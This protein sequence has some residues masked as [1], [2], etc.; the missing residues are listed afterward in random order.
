MAEENHHSG[1]FKEFMQRVINQYNLA[2]W[3][4]AVVVNAMFMRLFGT[5]FAPKLTFDGN[6]TMEKW[7]LKLVAYK[8][9]IRLLAIIGDVGDKGGPIEAVRKADRA[10]AA[11]TS[12]GKSVLR[13]AYELTIPKY[14]TEKEVAVRN[15]IGEFLV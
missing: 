8:D 13:F 3:Q 5:A 7:E 11:L 10:L 15:A 1:G 2:E 12:S 4:K 9:P 14:L 6:G